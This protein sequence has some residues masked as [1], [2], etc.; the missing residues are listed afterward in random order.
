MPID[1]FL[2]RRIIA[3]AESTLQAAGVVDILP[4]PLQRVA[5]AAGVAEV[6]DISE[7]PE[8][9][10]IRKPG[11]L[12]RILGAY[13]YRSDTA[14]VDL[15][16]PVGRRRFIFAHEARHKIVRWHHASHHLDD[17]VRLFQDTDAELEDEATWP[18]PCSCSKATGLTVGHL[19]MK[20]ACVRRSRSHPIT[21]PPCTPPCGSTS[22]TTPSR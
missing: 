15:S 19:S 3:T 4:T 1:P 17:E 22:S 6:V 2:R 9:L 18:A 20:P 10:V 11:P 7:L 16:Q 13:I 21:A 12:R 5:E 8:D 14:F